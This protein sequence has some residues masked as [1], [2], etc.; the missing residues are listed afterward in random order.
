MRIM[1]VNESLELGGSETMSVELANALT[2]YDDIQIDFVAAPG[3]LSKRLSYK[4]KYHSCSKFNFFK[5]L[6]ILGELTKLVRQLKP[7]VIHAHGAT[8]GIL[9]GVSAK[10]VN[11]NIKVVV[12]HHSKGFS[13]LPAWLSFYLFK[14]YCDFFIAITTNKLRSLKKGGISSK[15]LALIPNFVDIEHIRHTIQGVNRDDIKKELAILPNEKI[16]AMTGRLISSKRF[17]RFIKIL[18]DCSTKTDKTIVG[19]ILGE[20][21][22][23]KRLKEIARSL[24]RVNFRIIFLGYQKNVFRYLLAGDLFLFPSEHPEVL[25]MGLIEASA[26]GLPIVCSN[27]SGNDD[28]VEHGINGFLV[29]FEADYSESILRILNNI[30]LSKDLSRYG[31]ERAEKI[32]DKRIVVGKIMK[33]YKEC[34]V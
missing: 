25:P 24:E 4:V 3:L 26:L 11:K 7:D 17:D 23:L 5:I 10:W 14:H 22:E 30:D 1:I 34:C 8:I 33:V 12:T 9:A 19:L 2:F 15:R 29:N 31:V 6:V 21:P 18:Y 20:G 16:I 32:Y 27:I 28:I 13:R